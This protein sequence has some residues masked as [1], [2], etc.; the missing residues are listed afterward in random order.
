MGGCTDWLKNELGNAERSLRSF[1]GTATRKARTVER[2]MRRYAWMAHL[3]FD[4][5]L[6]RKCA[7]FYKAFWNAKWTILCKW[8][9]YGFSTPPPVPRSA[10]IIGAACEPIFAGTR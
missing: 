6:S 1:G 10:L 5:L 2:Y 8:C 3:S 9:K 4:H 7:V